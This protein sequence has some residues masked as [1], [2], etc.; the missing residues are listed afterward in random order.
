MVIPMMKAA[1]RA[2]LMRAMKIVRIPMMMEFMVVAR[3][4]T[5]K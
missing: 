4:K 3:L 2:V 1:I 5:L